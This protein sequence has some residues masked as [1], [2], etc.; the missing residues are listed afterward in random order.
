M[1]KKKKPA[2]S[3]QPVVIPQD[4][5]GPTDMDVMLRQLQIAESECMASPDAKQKARNKQHIL[6]LR[7]RIAKLNAGGG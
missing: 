2:P 5:Q 3:I 1:K 7:E 6:E 4:T